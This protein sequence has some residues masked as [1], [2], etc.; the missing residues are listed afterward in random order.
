[1][2]ENTTK[3]PEQAAQESKTPNRDKFNARMKARYPDREF[4]DD[5]ELFGQIDSDYEGAEKNEQTIGALNDMLM[6]DPKAATFIDKWHENGDP[7]VALIEEY[8][9]EMVRGLNDPE[10][11]EAI[12]AANQKYLAKIARDKE[13][14]EVIS[15]NMQE[16]QAFVDGKKAEL[17]EETVTKVLDLIKQAGLE[18][19]T[20]KITP[21]VFGM[22]L[23]AVNH[24]SDVAQAS[25]EGE[26]RGRNANISAKVRR[27][28]AGDGVPNVGGGSQMRAQAPK[29]DLG[30]LD[31]YNQSTSIWDRG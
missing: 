1:M 12:A 4:A 16:A 20:G 26:V 3:K 6:N 19:I 18:F 27:G 25:A 28:K 22:A 8:G 13:L 14:D 11:K 7:L 30:V 9:E 21:A 15:N 23:A 10:K 29:R 24:D 5:E 31:R 17:G 2:A